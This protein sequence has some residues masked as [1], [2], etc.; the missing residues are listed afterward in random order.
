MQSTDTLHLLLVTCCVGLLLTLSA[1]L[2]LS[3]NASVGLWLMQIIPLCLALPGVW[4][5]NARALQWLGFLVL[6][7][8]LNGVLQAFSAATQQR[9]LGALTLLLCLTL[10]TAV[11]VAIRRRTRPDI[12]RH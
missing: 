7:Y 10:F 1:P 11:I 12:P 3:D 5:R 8:F 4:K 6:F 2:L 9:W